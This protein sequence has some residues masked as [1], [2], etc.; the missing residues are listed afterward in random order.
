MP[1]KSL[2]ETQPHSFVY[3][4]SIARWLHIPMRPAEPEAFMI[5]PYGKSL[6]VSSLH[7]SSLAAKT[8][9]DF[10]PGYTEW[11]IGS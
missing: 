2:T 4:L 6:P 5:R 9:T 1:I 3:I 10:F 11:L 8:F 7:H